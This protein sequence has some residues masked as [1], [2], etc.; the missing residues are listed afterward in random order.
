MP[1]LSSLKHQ[2]ERYAR[3][4]SRFLGA[5]AFATVPLSVYCVLDGGFL[6]TTLLGPQW[7]GAA[8]VFRILAAAGVVQTIA[9]TRG[10]VL[11]SLGRSRKYLWLGIVNS[12]VMVLSFV[13]GLPYGIMG[14]A[15]AYAVANYLILVPTLLFTFAG[16]PVTMR[17]FFGVL[18]RPIAFSAAA[19][20]VFFAVLS[21]AA[22]GGVLAHVAA[23]SVFFVTYGALAWRSKAFRETWAAFASGLLARRATS[24]SEAKPS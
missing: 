3:Y 22:N 5:L 17:A 23:G 11:V 1:A 18:W 10:L 9:S 14:V 4:Y 7:A 15:T 6:I 21:L 16:T 8:T 20:L 12:T 13:V 2:P 24:E 19:S